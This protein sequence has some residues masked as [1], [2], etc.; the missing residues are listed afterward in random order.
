MGEV[1][2]IIDG[3]ATIYMFGV[4][5][6][7]CRLEVISCFYVKITFLI[8]CMVLLA[9]HFRLVETWSSGAIFAWPMEVFRSFIPFNFAPSTM[10]DVQV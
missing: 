10:S 7:N 4:F 2:P 5:W 9:F 3:R 6:A 1:L 8:H